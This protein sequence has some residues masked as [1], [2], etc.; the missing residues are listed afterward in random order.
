M[1]PL[2]AG[3]A[4]DPGRTGTDNRLCV[5]GVFRVLRSGAHWR[6]LPQRYGKCRSVHKRFSRWAEGAGRRSS[7]R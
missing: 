5:N 4:G 3:T 7:P 6:D 1:A 2:L